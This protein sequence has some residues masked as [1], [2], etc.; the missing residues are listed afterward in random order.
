MDYFTVLWGGSSFNSWFF[1]GF[2]LP[3]NIVSPRFGHSEV[4]SFW[5]PDA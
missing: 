2:A 5:K 3:V 1:F 4:V